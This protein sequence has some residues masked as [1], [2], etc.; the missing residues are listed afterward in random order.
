MARVGIDGGSQGAVYASLSGV[1][2]LEPAG[3]R[4]ADA[5]WLLAVSRDLLA[6]P[7]LRSGLA[8][9][10]ARVRAAIP[11]D[12]FGVLL[13]DELGREL[14]FAHAEG[15]SPT[16]AEHWR[17]GFGQG[18]V[19]TVAATGEPILA[20]DVTL[21]PRY[22]ATLD[23]IR[24]ELAVPLKVK[25]RVIGVL[26]LASRELAAY[27][28]S[29]LA[30]ASVL[31]EHLAAAIDAQRLYDNV[32]AQAQMLSVLH[33]LSRELTAIL[34]RRR[35]ISRVAERLGRL[36]DFDC[37][38]IRL[39]NEVT[40][41]LDPWLVVSRDR[42]EIEGLDPMGLGVGISGTAAALRQVLRVPN[43]HLDPRYVQCRLELP[44][45]SELAV[46]LVFEDRLVGVVDLESVRYDAFTLEHE[47][48]LG[49]LASSLAIA[50]ANAELYENLQE[51]RR[52]LDED[53]RTAR[54]VQ[55][56]LL[57]RSSPW[58]PGLQVSAGYEP[59][60]HLGGD[61]YDFYPWGE[62][63]FA[64]A[65][66]DAAG[67]GTSAALYASLAVGMLRELAAGAAAAPEG[68]PPAVPGAP[69][70]GP[71]GGPAEVLGRLNC[72]LRELDIPNRF[73]AMGFALYDSATRRLR[74]AN[75]GLPYPYFVHDGAVREIEMGGVPLG[76][77]AGKPYR[78]VE[79]PF[80]P[81]DTLVLASDGLAEARDPA[82]EE[83]GHERLAA[84]V[85]R[86]AQGKANAVAG[87]LL[88][89]VRRFAE[90]AEPS[91]DRTVVV[92]RACDAGCGAGTE[93]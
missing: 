48:L 8:A 62:G 45:R 74:L 83:F 20:P 39:W 89:A 52:R 79:L 9:V 76:L 13:L 32:R 18:I 81:G 12:E 33:E 60:R 3:A 73:V 93:D 27:D 59:A 54:E 64:V 25:E 77:L 37:F 65:V 92:L 91:D 49:T 57:P 82:G 51:G 84:A 63:R 69:E 86:L 35:V 40:R 47:Q 58:A 72:R 50:L 26:D 67:K 6:A 78:E 28:A 19:G 7:D 85:A 90:P 24:S 29:D 68:S 43:V 23:G 42:Q 30:A 15:T 70:S 41:T 88:E 10:A 46:P 44:V 5:E 38:S 22:L 87:G 14:K 1:M 75:S 53:L 66:G 36:I 55:L 71:V 34:D 80:A 16:V 21:D 31:A 4:G 17:F 2:T 56:R 11:Y 61:F